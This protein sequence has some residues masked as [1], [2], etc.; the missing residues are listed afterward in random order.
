ME[1]P[2]PICSP[3]LEVQVVGPP[4]VLRRWTFGEGTA[5]AAMKNERYSRNPGMAFGV[6][7]QSR[8]VCTLP[9]ALSTG[10]RDGRWEGWREVPVEKRRRSPSDTHICGK[11]AVLH[12]GQKPLRFR[13][14]TLSSVLA[15]TGKIWS[16]HSKGLV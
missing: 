7:V 14:F 9:H 4:N 15:A 13:K 5:C 6:G 1:F 10:G 16:R 12:F 2:P 3:N 8:K 11:S